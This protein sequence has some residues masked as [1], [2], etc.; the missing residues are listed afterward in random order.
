MIEFYYGI[1]L[2]IYYLIDDLIIHKIENV[3]LIDNIQNI[4]ILH[5]FSLALFM[6]LSAV[7]ITRYKKNRMINTIYIALGYLKYTSLFEFTDSISNYKFEL[8]R[9][10]MW[11]FITPAMLDIYTKNN[12]ISFYD[13]KPFYHI[14]PNIILLL[15]LPLRGKY[16]IYNIIY[17]GLLTS[18]LYFVM[19][20][21]KLSNLKYT[22]IFL[23]TWLLFG[24]LDLLNLLKITNTYENNLYYFVADIIAKLTV[25]IL[26]YD[27]DEQ[28]K[29]ITDKI[30]L[31]SVDLMSL[32]LNTISEYKK[33]NVLTESCKIY[34]KYLNEQ[35]KTIY[36]SMEGRN[37]IKLELLKKLLPC[38]LD[39][40]YLLSNIRKYEQKENICIMFVDI[41]SYS[42]LASNESAENVYEIL[43]KIYTNFDIILRKYK[44][45]QK[46]ETIGDSYMVVG[47][48]TSNINILL[49]VKNMIKIAEE[50]ILMNNTI[51]YRGN[52]IDIRI[53][54]N[55]GAVVIGILGL[56]IPR[57]CVVGN[58]VNKTARL[59]STGKNN[60][61][62]IS[63]E[64]YELIKEDNSYTF[65]S[66]N[67]V[68][69][70][71]IGT[72]TTYFVYK[73]ID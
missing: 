57:L 71:N 12:N 70:K 35:I 43:D 38:D 24:S 60:K 39:D 66:N 61:I 10:L 58:T 53:G 30:D 51:I 54:I 16:N 25:N 26:I 41:V 4:K 2:I 56:D 21:S 69:L 40:K 7:M 3:D 1:L 13:V 33:N 8:R 6:L 46:I 23:G 19:N 47:D 18:Y 29:T 73:K 64:V 62:H 55:I 34:I 67:N 37:V 42:E 49:V 28:K 15:I 32:V 17:I 9:N 68:Y 44:N 36:P 48:L 22:N 65:E 5:K 14:I 72:F 63:Q 50:F 59:E 31:Q 27:Q 20:L 45:L 52:K 11:V